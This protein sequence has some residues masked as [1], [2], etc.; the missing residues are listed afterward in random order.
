[1]NR[2]KFIKD[3]FNNFLARKFGKNLHLYSFF[4][5]HER[6]P[7][8]FQNWEEQIKLAEEKNLKRFTPQDYVKMVEDCALLFCRLAINKKEQELKHFW[9]NS[10]LVDE[11]GNKLK[12]PIV[13][14]G[15]PEGVIEVDD[16]V[17]LFNSKP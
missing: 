17:N 2:Q 3:T 5:N 7:L 12:D 11:Y 8:V 10:K 16:R 15:M 14:P 1:M 4:K 6:L 13:D 9:V